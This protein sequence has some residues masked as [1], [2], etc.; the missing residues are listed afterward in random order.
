MRHAALRYALNTTGTDQVTIHRTKNRLTTL[1]GMEVWAHSKRH[2]EWQVH[3]ELP[4]LNGEH[5]ECQRCKA[6]VFSANFI[7]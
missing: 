3:L 1:C 4:V 5:K 7:G 6:G 2:P